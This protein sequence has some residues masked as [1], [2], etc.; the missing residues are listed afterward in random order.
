VPNVIK[1]FR[2][3]LMRT[4]QSEQTKSSIGSHSSMQSCIEACSRCAQVCL[5]TA[6][7]HCLELGGRHVEQE[8]FRL[9]MNC[10]EICQL[11]ANFMLSGSRFHNRTCEV[12]AEICEACAM[13]CS[14]VGDMEECESTCRQ[15]AESCRQMV[16]MVTH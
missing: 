6:M 14:R 4:S 8:H 3:N 10:A 1:N 13:D 2:R 16:G 9:M 12:C 15:C 5:Q 11:S 7:N